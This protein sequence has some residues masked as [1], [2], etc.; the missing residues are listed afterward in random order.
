MNYLARH[1]VAIFALTSAALGLGMGVNGIYEIG[2]Y[3]SHAV[4]SPLDRSLDGDDGRRY[5]DKIWTDPHV[6]D[7]SKVNGSI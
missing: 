5:Q 6:F 4:A 1:S 2:L 7:G 3:E